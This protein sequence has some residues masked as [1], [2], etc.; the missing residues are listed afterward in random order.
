MKLSL[1]RVAFALSAFPATSPAFSAQADSALS[2]RPAPV[3]I[4]RMTTAEIGNAIHAGATIVLI[5]S[6]STEA[7]G[8]AIALGKHLVRAQYITE[9]VAQELGNALVAPVMPFAPTTDESRFPHVQHHRQADDLRRGL[10]IAE[11][12]GSWISGHAAP[13]PS[14]RYRRP[15]LV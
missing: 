10:E 5:P 6:A 14:P 4:E 7:T 15:N 13:L 3:M 9:H 11:G 2:H 1:V 12:I 8:P